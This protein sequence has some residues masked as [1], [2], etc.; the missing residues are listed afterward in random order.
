MRAPSLG[1]LHSKKWTIV[2]P[3]ISNYTYVIC[4]PWMHRSIRIYSIYT[5]HVDAHIYVG[6]ISYNLYNIVHIF[7][8]V[9]FEIYIFNNS[10]KKKNKNLQTVRLI[11]DFSQSFWRL[12]SIRLP[13]HKGTWKRPQRWATPE[14]PTACYVRNKSWHTYTMHYLVFLGLN[15]Y[16]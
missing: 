9:F 7:V 8:H 14:V 10:H 4:I 6:I 3:C 11:K 15:L 2:M 16:I 1:L 13:R 12:L 5:W